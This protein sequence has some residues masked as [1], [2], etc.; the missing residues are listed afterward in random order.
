MIV[1]LNALLYAGAFSVLGFLLSLRGAA[2][3]SASLLTYR[4]QHTPSSRK[5]GFPA[6]ST[7][8]T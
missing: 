4:R 7:F 8:R 3:R 5:T 1:V 2:K 6:T